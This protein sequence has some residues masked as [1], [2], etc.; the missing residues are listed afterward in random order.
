MKEDYT[1]STVDGAMGFARMYAEPEEIETPDL[2]YEEEECDDDDY[3][4]CNCSD[5]G[6]PCGGYKTGRL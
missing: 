3:D 4:R 6:C 2:D 5:P 1:T